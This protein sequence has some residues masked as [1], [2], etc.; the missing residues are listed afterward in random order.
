MD[1]FALTEMELTEVFASLDLGV[2]TFRPT[3]SPYV[4]S[5]GTEGGPQPGSTVFDSRTGRPMANA[6]ASSSAVKLGKRRR[7]VSDS[8]GSGGEEEEDDPEDDDEDGG[9]GEEED[10]EEEEK[11]DD[12]DDREEELPQRAVRLS[13][14][15]QGKRPVAVPSRRSPLFLPSPSGRSPSPPAPRSPS[16]PAPSIPP[17]PMYTREELLETVAVGELPLLSLPLAF[18]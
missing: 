13:T 4:L 9:D 2:P 1:E 7:V 8:D 17:E 14:K 15:A 5:P 6:T 10:D 18:Y 11:E 12:G 3:D 16:V